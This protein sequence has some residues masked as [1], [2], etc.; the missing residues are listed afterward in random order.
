MQKQLGES[1]R[2]A[3]FPIENF[4]QHKLA[5]PNPDK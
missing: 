2:R 3:S 5:Q 4:R 1:A